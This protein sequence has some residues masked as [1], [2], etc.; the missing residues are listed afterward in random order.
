MYGASV[1]CRQGVS[2]LSRK[3]LSPCGLRE[4]HTG[5]G[6]IH[7]SQDSGQPLGDESQDATTEAELRDRQSRAITSWMESRLGTDK[8]RLAKLLQQNNC[9]VRGGVEEGQKLMDALM[10]WKSDAIEEIT[11]RLKSEPG[12]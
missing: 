4:A 8:V 9:V 10:A 6:Q 2:H 11:Q 5:I 12:A 7:Q 3:C 1:I